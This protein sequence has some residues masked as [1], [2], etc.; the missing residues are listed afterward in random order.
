VI[1]PAGHK[2]LIRPKPVVKNVGDIILVLDEARELA[3]TT[4]G[5]VVAIGETAYL[6]VDDGRPWVKV[7]DQVLYGKYAG[8]LAF[9][10]ETQA[11]YVVVHD[12]DIVCIVRETKGE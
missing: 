4:E 10:P 7:G 1:I 8:A 12:V 6:K 9:D 11:Q 2:V 5:E 3:A